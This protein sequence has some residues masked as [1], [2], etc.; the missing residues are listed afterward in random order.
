M[1]ALNCF[2]GMYRRVGVH[3]DGCPALEASDADE[4]PCTFCGQP[5]NT[6]EPSG[7][8]GD[9]GGS[10]FTTEGGEA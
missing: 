9:G 10:T 6:H 1:R 5:E 3:A 4:V 2:C 7:C 8:C